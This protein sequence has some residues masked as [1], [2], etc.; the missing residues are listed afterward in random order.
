MTKVAI[1][2]HGNYGYTKTIAEYIA[3]GAE[4]VAQSVELYQDLEIKNNL[5]LLD[6]IDAIIFGSPTYFGSVSTEFK[7]FMDSTSKVWLGQKWKDK[8]A[9][10]FSCSNSPC[11]DKAS[12]LMQLFIFACQHGMIWA[13]VD[14]HP[15]IKGFNDEVEV[16]NKLGS[17]V[18]FAIQ[19]L[20]DQ[21]E[22]MEIEEMD[23]KA[24]K[25]FGRRITEVARKLKGESKKR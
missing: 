16:Y 7:S 4:E 21:G 22:K 20:N 9:A 10:A 24:A 12:V 8:V 2:H 19:V 3:Q 5:G 25:L 18:G 13:G 6:E 15:H 1:I 11:G 23:I 14:L 17:Y